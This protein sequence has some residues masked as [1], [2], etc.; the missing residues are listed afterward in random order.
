MIVIDGNPCKV[1]GACGLCLGVR[2]A[3]CGVTQKLQT[4]M[5]WSGQMHS[6][7]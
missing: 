5:L 1:L 7:T 4:G 3:I 2:P 6:E